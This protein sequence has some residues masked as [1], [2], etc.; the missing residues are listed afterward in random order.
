MRHQGKITRWDDNKGFGFVAW[1]GGG[2]PVFVHIKA[3]RKGSRRPVVDDIITYELGKDERGR[4]RAENVS[5]PRQIVEEKPVKPQSSQPSIAIAYLWI[6]LIALCA[7]TVSKHLPPAVLLFY[8]GASAVTFIFYGFD[9]AAAQLGR[10]RT[11][12]STL[13]FL[14]LIGG[15]PGA[16]LAQRTM[17]HKTQKESFQGTFLGTIALNTAGLVA[18][19]IWHLQSTQN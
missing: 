5:F 15:W 1:H 19:F 17:R 10:W 8:A 6:F 7:A 11:P 2:S 14:G 3:F 18:M 12:E 16:L 4:P 9:K 13:Q